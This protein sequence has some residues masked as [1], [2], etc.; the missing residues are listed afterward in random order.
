MSLE[1]REL[2]KVKRIVAGSMAMPNQGEV[3]YNK[4]KQLVIDG[5]DTVLIDFDGIDII[6]TAFLNY[7]IGKFIIEYDYDTVY[8][9]IEIININKVN[10]L[11][12]LGTVIE[13]ARKQ[14]RLLRVNHN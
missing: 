5:G 11:K 13:E 12:M 14:R 10:D 8:K 6:T 4:L 1:N 9:K 2:I 7:S 3:L